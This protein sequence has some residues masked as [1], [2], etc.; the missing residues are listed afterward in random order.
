MVSAVPLALLTT[1]ALSPALNQPTAALHAAVLTASSGPASS[2]G[3]VQGFGDAPSMGGPGSSITK[4]VVG[5]AATP[6]GHGYWLVAADGGVFSY[7]NAGFHGSTGGRPL[8][9]PIVGIA[10]TPSGGGYWL[11]GADGGVFAFGDASFFGSAAGQRLSQPVVGMA[12]TPDGHGYWLVG[13]DGGVF[14]FGD[15]GFHGSTGS[16]HLDK[17]IVAIAATGTGHGYWLAAADGGIF[18]FGDAGFH[19]SAGGEHLDAPIVGLS[20]TPSGH[21]YWLAAADGG[22]FGFGDAGFS[23]SAS[24]EATGTQV[25]A[26]AATPTGG[27]YWLATAPTPPPQS[28]QAVQA[29]STPNGTPVGTFGI[30]CY[31]NSGHTASGATTSMQTVAV[32]PSVIPL[33]TR[34]YIAGVGTRVAQDTGGAIKGNRLDIWEPTYQDCMNWGYQNREVWRQG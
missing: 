33:G 34:I 28:T 2:P 11:V 13:A 21:G 17:P 24:P 9:S 12:A 3:V 27:G 18:A 23:G 4:P 25:A 30:T 19:G 10:P 31:D 8:S 22:V 5:M 16:I 20:R 32:D 15:A 6:D 29:A 14:A 7:G 26:M 1:A